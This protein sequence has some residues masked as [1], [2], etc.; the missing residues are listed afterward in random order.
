[1]FG[2]KTLKRN[3]IPVTFE[4]LSLFN[5][6]IQIDR[7]TLTLP[8]FAEN[9]DLLIVLGDGGGTYLWMGDEGTR[10]QHREPFCCC[11]TDSTTLFP[12]EEYVSQNYQVRT[13][14]H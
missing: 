6:Y 7:L 9:V 12:S 13:L 11:R 10:N 14:A 8:L 2:D 3:F 5:K 4:Q 1:M